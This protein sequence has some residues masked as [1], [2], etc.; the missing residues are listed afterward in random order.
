MANVAG[1]AAAFGK[2][3]A[4]SVGATASG[5]TTAPP[6]GKKTAA[7]APVEAEETT[8]LSSI[9]EADETLGAEAED[10]SGFGSEEA[11]EGEASFDD[12]SDAPANGKATPAKNKA[13]AEAKAAKGP[14]VT[15][16]EVNAAL[17]KYMKAQGKTKPQ[18]QALLK[19][20]FN[21]ES[22]NELK[23]TQYAAVIAAVTPKTK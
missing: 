23:E 20:H 19:K 22:V 9:G 21:I 5:A 12:I 6:K 7:P 11:G 14:K 18:V 4:A 16:K 2:L 17:I 13:V 15:L 8:E 10:E 1:Q 3:A